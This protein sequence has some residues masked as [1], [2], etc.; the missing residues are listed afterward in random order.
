MPQSPTSLEADP[1]DGFRRVPNEEFDE[2]EREL[3]AYRG[4]AQTDD[5]LAN[6]SYVLK[7]NSLLNELEK[8]SSPLRRLVAHATQVM[9]AAFHDWVESADPESGQAMD[10]HRN[11]RAARL[12]ID[13]VEEQIAVGN[14]A[15][16]QLKAGEEDE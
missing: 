15:E 10:S 12:V 16:G 5:D 9:D 3:L 8:Q 2:L 14:Q 11:A 13:W 1:L 6:L 7:R 4:L